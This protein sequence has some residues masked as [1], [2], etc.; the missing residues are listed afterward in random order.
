M[1]AMRKD[2]SDRKYSWNMLTDLALLRESDSTNTLPTPTEINDY[3]EKFTGKAAP[4]VNYLVPDQIAGEAA[5][6]E[7]AFSHTLKPRLS[8]T[9][10]CLILRKTAQPQRCRLVGAGYLHGCMQG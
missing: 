2:Q 4:Y 9:S 1:I 6:Y 10:Y 5:H 3:T 8:R 7:V